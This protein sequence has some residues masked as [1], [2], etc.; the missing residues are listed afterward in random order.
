[1]GFLGKAFEKAKSAFARLKSKF[2]AGGSYTGAPT[3]GTD[4]PEQDADDL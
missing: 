2:D 4:D 3:D 1:M